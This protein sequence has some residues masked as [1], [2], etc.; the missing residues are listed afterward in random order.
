MLI[1]TNRGFSDDI[2]RGANGWTHSGTSD[3]WHQTAHRSQS[4]SHSWY[5]GVEN[6]WQYTNENTARLVTPYFV[7][8]E[9]ARVSFDQWY[10]VELDYD[11]CMPEINN[12]SDFWTPLASYTGT[13]SNW[14]HVQFPLADWSGQTIRIGFRFLSD[15]GVTAEGWYLDNL[16]CEPY[17]S[18]V[19]EPG[20]SVQVQYAKLEI[21]SPA[22]RTASIAY[23]VPAGRSARLAAF[24]VNG[25]LV[26]EIA[27]R[28][29][30]AGHAAWNLAGVEAGAYFVRLSDEASSKVVKVVVAK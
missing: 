5:C 27:N 13:N 6:S 15:G 16:L 26:G 18:G 2:E 22:F 8:G 21:H 7:S 29:T 4:S 10:N 14:E 24:D 25:R 9:S 19:A 30:G 28:L 23:A 17:L 11:Y 20:R 3:N 1:T 12:G